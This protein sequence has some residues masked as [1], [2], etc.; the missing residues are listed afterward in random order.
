V[1]TPSPNPRSFAEL[2]QGQIPRPFAS[3]RVTIP[4]LRMT[5]GGLRII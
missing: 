1:F 5:I 2:I 4:A 3:L